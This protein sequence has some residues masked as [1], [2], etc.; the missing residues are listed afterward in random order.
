MSFSTF[1]EVFLQWIL[2]C[3]VMTCKDHWTPNLIVQWECHVQLVLTVE[4]V[5][6]VE[7]PTSSA[8]IICAMHARRVIDLSRRSSS[9]EYSSS[10]KTTV[11]YSIFRSFHLPRAPW[12]D[13][14]FFRGHYYLSLPHCSLKS[15]FSRPFQKRGGGGWLPDEKV[16][17]ARRTARGQNLEFW[18]RLG[19]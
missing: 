11:A 14:L 3:A 8:D 19:C 15:T 12:R 10:N 4:D 6:H 18:Y 7:I 2:G 9:T 5:S 13:E 16:G 17:D 1:C